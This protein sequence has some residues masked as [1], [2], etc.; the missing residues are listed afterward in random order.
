[1]STKTFNSFMIEVPIIR[2][3]SINL[4]RKSIGWFL[5]SGKLPHER[6]KSDKF[7]KI[8]SLLGDNKHRGKSLALGENLEIRFCQE[9]FPVGLKMY[10]L[11]TGKLEFDI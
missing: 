11:N 7:L 8:C 3:Q 6:V 9:V 1:M 4:Q 5:F 10:G 2:N